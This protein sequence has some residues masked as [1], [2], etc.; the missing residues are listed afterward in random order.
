MLNHYLFFYL[1]SDYL[2]P[3]KEKPSSVQ[4][5]SDTL[6]TSKEDSFLSGPRTKI[7]ES[8]SPYQFRSLA[9]PEHDGTQDDES[10]QFERGFRNLDNSR[11]KQRSLGYGYRP[12]YSYSGRY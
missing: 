8:K 12:T 11:S 3:T 9:A 6:N 10:Y 4:M 7:S 2:E 1:F 5:L